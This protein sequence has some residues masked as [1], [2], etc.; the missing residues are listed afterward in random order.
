MI[1]PKDAISIIAK[2]L[3]ALIDSKELDASY[4]ESDTTLSVYID[5]IKLGR[6]PLLTLRLSD[7]NVNMHYFFQNRPTNPA[8]TTNLSIEFYIPKNKDGKKIRNRVRHN[9][10]VDNRSHA[11]PFD[12]TYFSYSSKKLVLSDIE[13]IYQQILKYIKGGEFIDPFLKT[14]KEA[15][16]NTVHSRFIIK[17]PRNDVPQNISGDRVGVPSTDT[18]Y[19]ADYVSES[20]N[21]KYPNIKTEGRNVVRLT[22]S[23]LKMI[24]RECIKKALN[25][26]YS[27]RRLGC[28][29]V[30]KGDNQPHSIKGLE[31]YGNALYD[32]R[33]YSNV[34]DRKETFA[35]FSIGKNT[36]KYI[37][38]RLEFD[39]EYGTWLGFTPIKNY[40]VPTMI[41]QDLKNNPIN[42]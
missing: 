38:C 19:G 22:E 6:I 29:D 31:Q 8:E 4:D 41:K 20:K 40:D 42:Q 24:I 14:D 39:E 28:F 30:V 21:Q 17:D 13:P 26:S 37:C 18:N 1:N 2:R 27:V 32:V 11:T 34:S 7:H 16:T 10:T 5:D 33:L 9:V 15:K 3:K 25:E 23:N 36:S 35:I 12:I